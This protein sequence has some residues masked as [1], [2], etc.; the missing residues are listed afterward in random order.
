MIT[1]GTGSNL[2]LSSGITKEKY[3]GSSMPHQERANH[4]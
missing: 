4:A 3:D 2:F 1:L